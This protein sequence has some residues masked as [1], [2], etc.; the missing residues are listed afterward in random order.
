MSETKEDGTISKREENLEQVVDDETKS[1]SS[2]ESND[3]SMF[4]SVWVKVEVMEEGP[5]FEKPLPEKEKLTSTSKRKKRKPQKVLKTL[6]CEECDY[7]TVYKN[8]LQLHIL[9]HTNFKPFSCDSCDYVTKYPSSLQRHVLTQ[10]G[11]T[12]DKEKELSVYTCE[13]CPYTSY[14]KCNLNSHKRKHKLEKEFKCDHCPYTTAYRHNFVKHSKVH[15]KTDSHRYKCD[16]CP[17]VTKFE[18]H[19]TRHLAKIHNEVSDK[20]NRCDLCD[21]STKVRWRLNIHKQRSKQEEVMKCNYCDFETFYRC[22]SKKHKVTHYSEIYVP[23]N[24]T[25]YQGNA[26]NYQETNSDPP[27]YDI[28]LEAPETASQTPQKKNNHYKIDPVCEVDWNNIQVSESSDKDKPF[29]CTMC[30]YTARFKASVQRHYQRHHTGSHNRPYKCV[31]CDFSTKTKDQISLHNKRSQSDLE[32]FCQNCNFS[33]HFKC[34]YVM[35]QKCHYEHKCT[36]SSDEL[37]DQSGVLQ[38]YYDCQASISMNQTG[39]V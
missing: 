19:I 27:V 29:K 34:Q 37:A 35:H 15:N 18:G 26:F 30:Q 2:E 25:P 33:T 24:S 8:C 16:K 1:Q 31:N 23:K 32:I 38:D 3:V 21:F 28:T 10:H 14:Y 5:E 17:F 22:E 9:G 11:E 36:M 12:T 39:P 7:T 13:Q 6:Q 20:A 4:A